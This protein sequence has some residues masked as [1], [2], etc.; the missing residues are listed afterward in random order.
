MPRTKRKSPAAKIA[1]PRGFYL[2]R[3]VWYARVYRPHPTTHQW[4]MYPESTGHPEAELGKAIE[5]VEGRNKQLRPAALLRRSEDPSKITMDELF[6]ALLLAQKHAPTKQD[7]EWSLKA[8][9]RPYFGKMLAAELTVEHCRAYRAMRRTQLRNGRP[10]E[11]TTI[12]R[13]VSKISR[14]F[15]LAIE[16]GKLQSMPPGGCDFWKKPE[17]QNTR[18]VRLPD[19]YYAVFRDAIHPALRCAFV[20]AYHIGRRKGDVLNIEW[21]QIHFEERCIYFEVTKTGPVKCPFMGE[22][23]NSLRKQKALRDK[24]SPGNP[25]VCFWFQLRSN[26]DGEPIKRF[27]TAW[28]HAAD[29]LVGK[30]KTDGVE[31]IDLHFHDLRRSA[32]YQMRKA[33]IDAH[34]RRAIMGHKTGS[35]DD[36][37]TMIDDE[38][39]ADARG[40]MSTYLR[41]TPADELKALRARVAELEAIPKRAKKRV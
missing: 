24:F 33:G 35:M 8:N 11:H 10:I 40:K 15:K 13:E 4:G 9:L 36:R 12:N 25:N 34:T 2:K 21:N 20:L 22:M 3:G 1:R 16:V 27:D 38:A 31:P 6:D 19:R 32:H 17:T 28:K 26:K 39:L 18:R 7:Y 37:Y 41:K 5:H 23:E 30:M 29:A 14:A